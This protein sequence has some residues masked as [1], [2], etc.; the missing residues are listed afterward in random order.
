MLGRDD[1]NECKWDLTTLQKSLMCTCWARKKTLG[2]LML[3]R[4]MAIS[5]PSQRVGV[6]VLSGGNQL[7]IQLTYR[8]LSYML[9]PL[10]VRCQPG[11]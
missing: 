11:R 5:E 7:E 6:A 1:L 2:R 4:E 10:G 9:G 3:T 8:S